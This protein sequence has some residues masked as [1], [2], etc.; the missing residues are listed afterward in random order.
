MQKRT[1]TVGG[2]CDG[3]GGFY[4]ALDE[5]LGRGAYRHMFASEVDAPTRRL[6]SANFDMEKLY[7]DVVTR[8]H[9]QLPGVD[10]YVASPPCQPFP[11]EQKSGFG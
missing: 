11:W 2:D 3:I 8:D 5:I 1:L 6:L 10:M 9:S 4:F 7:H